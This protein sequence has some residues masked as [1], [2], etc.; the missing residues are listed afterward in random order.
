[1]GTFFVFNSVKWNKGE[2]PSLEINVEYLKFFAKVFLVLRWSTII[3]APSI[4]RILRFFTQKVPLWE[5]FA[6][7]FGI[8]AHFK[9]ATMVLILAASNRLR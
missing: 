3:D 7:W 8:F 1:M 5:F 9:L 6:A 2:G 4:F